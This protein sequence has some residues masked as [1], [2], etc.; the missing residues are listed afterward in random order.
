MEVL[1]LA[2]L[3]VICVFAALGG[4]ISAQKYRDPIEGAVLG[5]LFGPLGCLIAALL[6]TQPRPTLGRVGR[7]GS[8]PSKPR[9]SSSLGTEWMPDFPDDDEVPR[10]ESTDGMDAQVLG[11]LNERPEPKLDAMGEAIARGLSRKPKPDEKD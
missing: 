4:W 9:K 7:P 2:G 1:I 8:V 11:F 6:P 5:G 10:V 3:V